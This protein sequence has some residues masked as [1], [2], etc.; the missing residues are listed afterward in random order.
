MDLPPW[1][2][3]TP[4]CSAVLLINCECWPLRTWFTLLAMCSTWLWPIRKWI[5]VTWCDMD[6][7]TWLERT[8]LDVRCLM[9]PYGA[10]WCLIP[11]SI[12]LACLGKRSALNQML[13]P[14]HRFNIG[15]HRFNTANIKECS[16]TF[17]SKTQKAC[18][19]VKVL[20]TVLASS[21][22]LPWLAF[23]RSATMRY[24]PAMTHQLPH[25]RCPSFWNI[26]NIE[27]TPPASADECYWYPKNWRLV[28]AVDSIGDWSQPRRIAKKICGSHVLHQI[29]PN[30]VGNF[31]RCKFFATWPSATCVL[32]GKPH[33]EYH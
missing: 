9:V 30:G 27:S 15:Q 14:G 29:V 1:I 19:F 23:A 3:P 10:L 11:P 12:C 18:C 22:L 33:T 21:Y 20:H 6:W 31:C 2:F 5:P 24:H 8:T 32:T 4:G 26:L 25:H 16:S 7:R 17:V 28:P 13:P